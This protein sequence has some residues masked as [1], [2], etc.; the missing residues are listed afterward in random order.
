MET[1]VNPL[2]FALLLTSLYILRFRGWQRPFALWPAIFFL[3][4]RSAPALGRFVWD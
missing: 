3:R 2:A 4:M 1:I